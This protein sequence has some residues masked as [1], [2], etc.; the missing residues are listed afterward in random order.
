MVQYTPSCNATPSAMKSD[1]IRGVVS[2]E[3][4]SLEVVYYISASEIWRPLVAQV[5]FINDVTTVEQ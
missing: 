5:A 2:L 4:G 1:L 3:G